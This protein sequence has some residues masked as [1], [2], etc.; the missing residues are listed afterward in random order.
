MVINFLW[1]ASHFIEFAILYLLLTAALIV[2]KRY[3]TLTDLAAM[4][5]TI[6]YAFMDEIHQFYVPGRSFS[7]LDLVK[8]M[9]GVITAWILMESYQSRKQKDNH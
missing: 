6:A 3:N 8:D 2:N 4:S 1:E 9:A 5:V 7:Q